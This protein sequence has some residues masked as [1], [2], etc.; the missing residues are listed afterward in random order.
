M[1]YSLQ[2]RN[3][4]TGRNL[5]WTFPKIVPKFV[6][7]NLPNRDIWRR[8][9][10][11]WCAETFATVTHVKTWF[12]FVVKWW[13]Q[14]PTSS[15]GQSTRKMKPPN[16]SWV[17][18]RKRQPRFIDVHHQTNVDLR[19]KFKNNG[20]AFPS[21]HGFRLVCTGRTYITPVTLTPFWFG[22]VSLTCV[23]LPLARFNKLTTVV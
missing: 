10:K 4:R 22:H 3:Y 19:E 14:R 15:D 1:H 18:Y 17:K 7:Q 21:F 9:R 13:S 11:S 5:T 2:Y 23:F 8:D 12:F 20:F 16:W 6:L